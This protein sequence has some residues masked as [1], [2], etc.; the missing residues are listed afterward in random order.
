MR[1][2]EVCTRTGLTRRAIRFYAEKGLIT[3]GTDPKD[4]NDYRDYSEEDVQRLMLIAGL[5]SLRLT[6]D[7]IAAILR[8]P[9]QSSEIFTRHRALLDEER[10]EICEILD[11]LAKTPGTDSLSIL[12]DRLERAKMGVSPDMEPDFSRFEE[13]T[14]EERQEFADG[15]AVIDRIRRKKQIRT[16]VFALAAAVIVLIGAVI[17]R[18]IWYD[19]QMLGFSNAVGTNVQL[20]DL[21]LGEID[22]EYHFY[23][24]VKYDDPPECADGDTFHLPVDTKRNTGGMIDA[25]IPGETYAGMNI[26]GSVPR[27][28]AREYGILSGNGYLDAGKAMELFYTD[29]VFA[30]KYCYIDRF[31]SGYNIR[32]LDKVFEQ[33]K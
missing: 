18:K 4:H 33:M 21:Q 27:K 29:P 7:D 3:P 14:E 6:V 2:K 13:L 25:L 1:I 17:G 23:A 24:V 9:G 32:P 19:R 8:S 31:Y 12:A 26:H 10:A 22:G 28:T 20:L 5:R 30:R 16:A 11:I 15:G